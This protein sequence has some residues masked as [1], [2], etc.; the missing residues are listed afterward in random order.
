MTN[1]VIF[2]AAEGWIC[3]REGTAAWLGTGWQGGSDSSHHGIT[4]HQIAGLI[5]AQLQKDSC[6]LDGFKSGLV[7]FGCF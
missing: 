1:V 2:F 3:I 7:T 4:S 6:S 5:L